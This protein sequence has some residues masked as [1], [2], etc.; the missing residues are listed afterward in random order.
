MAEKLNKYVIE[1]WHEAGVAQLGNASYRPAVSETH[2]LLPQLMDA[3]GMRMLGTYHLDPQHRAY[4]IM[5]ARSV[6]D[7]RDV[8][9]LSK[10][11]HWCDGRIYPATDLAER[12]FGEGLPPA[13]NA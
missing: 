3:R 5:E 9:Y 12:W 8:L 6:E 1:L 2:H 7:V 10:F 13:V 4:L 11:M